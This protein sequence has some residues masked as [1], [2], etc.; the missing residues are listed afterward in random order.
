MAC[1]IPSSSLLLA[2]YLQITR[3]LKAA[4][5]SFKIFL[6]RWNLLGAT[7]KRLSIINRY[8]EFDIKS[9]NSRLRAVIM[10]LSKQINGAL[11]VLLKATLFVIDGRSKVLLWTYSIHC[12]IV[13]RSGTRGL[14]NI[15]PSPS[16][17]QA[18]TWTSVHLKRTSLKFNH[19]SSKKL[20]PNFLSAKC[21]S[22]VKN[23]CNVSGYSY[24]LWIWMRSFIFYQIS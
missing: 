5:F 1:T 8:E 16:W 24:L 13:P 11:K 7:A 15:G 20:K 23:T 3:S 21:Q 2:F 19:L 6:S 14:G 4:R 17:L 22:W 10:S 9:Y 18:I 12:G